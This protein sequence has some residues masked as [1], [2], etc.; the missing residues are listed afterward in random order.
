MKFITTG[1]I[2]GALLAALLLATVT[3]ASAAVLNGTVGFSGTRLFSF[4][5]PALPDP[6]AISYIDFQNPVDGG[7]GE[8]VSGGTLGD[9]TALIPVSTAGTIKDM[10][11]AANANGYT[12]VPVGVPVSI[13]NFIT[14]ASIP[15]VNFRLTSLPL[16]ANCGGPVTCVGAFQLV[17][18]GSN[19]SVSINILGEVLSGPD[20]TP[21]SGNITAQFLGTNVGAVIA[22]ASVPGGIL[23]NSWSG[24]IV[25]EVPEPST[26]TMLGLG[27]AAMAFG[28]RR[29]SSSK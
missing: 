8:L 20:T 22:G 14:F 17:Q 25:S 9:Y 29:R 21:F 24:A 4:S 11:T 23:A 13:D 27:L 12:V 19:V 1:A 5:I 6:T 3:P 18:N 10:A 7:F 26:I 16:A 28:A 15:A 2:K